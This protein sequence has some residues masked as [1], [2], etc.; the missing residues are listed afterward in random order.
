MLDTK[1][2]AGAISLRPTLAL[3]QHGGIPS[4]MA[5]FKGHRPVQH[6]AAQVM[7]AAIAFDAKEA[8]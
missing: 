3:T 1:T 7:R 5:T 4:C 8:G 2:E 6:V